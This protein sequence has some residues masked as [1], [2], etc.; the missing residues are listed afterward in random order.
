MVEKKKKVWWK[1][2][3]LLIV[4]GRGDQAA[5]GAGRQEGYEIRNPL[6]C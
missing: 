6:T 3:K 2:K 5:E 4:G 1:K